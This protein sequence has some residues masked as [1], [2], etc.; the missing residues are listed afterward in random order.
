MGTIRVF[1]FV[2]A[3]LLL[4][5]GVAAAAG[6]RQY[7][8]HLNGAQE[9]PPAGVVVETNGQGQARFTLSEDGQRLAYALNVANTAPITQ[10]HIHLGATGQ[11]GAIVVDLA[12]YGPLD[13]TG[14]SVERNGRLVEGEI[15]AASLKGP[16]A[17]QPLSALVTMLESGD[18]YVNVHTLRYPAGEVRGQIDVIGHQ[19][20]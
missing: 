3:G 8:A 16:L 2:L 17:G 7:R 1:T 14:G 18:A 15:T 19:H 6:A 4:L 5:G 20:P 10:A 9:I 13:G 12:I 11:N